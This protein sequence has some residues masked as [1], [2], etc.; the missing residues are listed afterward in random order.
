MNRRLCQQEREH[1]LREAGPADLGGRAWGCGAVAGVRP[2]V[3]FPG[4]DGKG[5]RVVSVGDDPGKVCPGQGG[6]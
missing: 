2:R 3:T 1:S 4:G 5:S 6:G